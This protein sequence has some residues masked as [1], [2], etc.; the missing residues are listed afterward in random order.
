MLGV[1]S[2]ANSTKYMVSEAPGLNTQW[3]RLRP[4]EPDCLSSNPR[5]VLIEVLSVGTSLHPLFASISFS[6]KLG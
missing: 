2:D 4:L 3:L 6:L 1:S 5:S